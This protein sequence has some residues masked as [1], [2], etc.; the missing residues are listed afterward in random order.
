MD[1]FSV[2]KVTFRDASSVL[3]V[4]DVLPMINT[5]GGFLTVTIASLNPKPRR[6]TFT[7]KHGNSSQVENAEKALL[8]TANIQIIKPAKFFPDDEEFSFV[9]SAKV[10][11]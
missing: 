7:V 6:A 2:K 5:L 1:L 10:K 3:S 11:C 8:R 9:H 4:M